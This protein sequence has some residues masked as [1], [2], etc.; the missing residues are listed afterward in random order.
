MRITT[1]A[2]LGLGLGL[3]LAACRGSGNH[4][5]P[6]AAMDPD[7]PMIDASSGVYTIK[8][9]QNDSMAVGTAVK[10][11]GV[12]V[13]AIDMFGSGNGSRTGD[14]WV[15][16][17]AGGPFSGVKVF[18][19]PLAQ[20]AQLAVGD[21]IDI[22]GAQ[23]DEFMITGDT[24]KVTEIKPVTGGAMMV[25]KR[26]TGTVP[27]PAMVDAAAISLMDDPVRDAE[28]EKW[29]GVLIT[30][31]N[32]RQLAALHTFG[33]GATD[34]TQ[35]PLS[36]GLQAESSLA[37]LPAGNA[38]GVCYDH[39][40][41]I[42]DYAFNYLVLP[43]STADLVVGGTG[44]RGMSTS[45]V[46]A[47]TQT[48][49]EAA[50][51]TNVYVTARGPK[52]FWVAD[53]LAAAA[54]NGVYVFTST[55]PDANAVIGATV[56]VQGTILEFD[57]AP[58]AGDSVTEITNATVSTPVPPGGT[59]PTPIVVAPAT[60]SDIGA[61]G[62]VYEGVLVQVAT[63]KVTKAL[64]GGQYEFTANDNSKII[65]DDESFAPTVALNVGDCY[66][67]ITGLMSIDL[68]NNVRTLNPRQAADLVTGAGCN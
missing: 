40:T 32:V 20:L 51:L 1:L 7:A 55:A 15:E 24:R 22:D 66:G 36:G 56:N 54:S 18:N 34:Q 5:G 38:F 27:A 25:T 50:N 12:V 21:L 44:C 14:M 3:S 49:P 60:L 45:I 43:R 41:G 29:E 58:L 4:D 57:V 35:F 19:T 9:V 42:G 61:P 26:G 52:G 17:L 37:A 2:L 6:D 65:M 30:V 67:S 63:V 11:R 8:D 16:D 64:A 28:W 13:T 39:I 33:K 68:T 48:K 46:E 59:L 47:Q 31:V 62:E 10:L 23:K 53:A